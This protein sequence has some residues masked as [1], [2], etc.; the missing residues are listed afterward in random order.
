MTDP[1]AIYYKKEP[2]HHVWKK[3]WYISE[4]NKLQNNVVQSVEYNHL[5][6]ITKRVYHHTNEDKFPTQQI[7][8]VSGK[9][10]LEEIW[11]VPDSEGKLIKHRE[12]EPAHILYADNKP[13][14]L[15]YYTNNVLI[16]TELPSQ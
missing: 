9:Y 6:A 13:F 3:V 2:V 10:L 15:K 11:E 16:K 4:P 5:G 14:L 8:D 7:F 12:N 1:C